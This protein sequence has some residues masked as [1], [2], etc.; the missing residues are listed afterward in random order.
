MAQVTV[1]PHCGYDTATRKIVVGAAKGAGVGLVML[2]DPI[3][4]ALALTGM[5]LQAWNN[6]GKTETQCPNCDKYYHN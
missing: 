3:L 1:C 4:G 5:A 6:S 2:I